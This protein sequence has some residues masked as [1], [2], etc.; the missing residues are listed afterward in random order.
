MV[1]L[2]TVLLSAPQSKAGASSSSSLKFSFLSTP[3]V[4]PN[5]HFRN[6]LRVI[7]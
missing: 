5:S 2:D 1:S 7:S 6:V 4:P 3:S